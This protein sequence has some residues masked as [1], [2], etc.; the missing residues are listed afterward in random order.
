MNTTRRQFLGF[1]MGLA[2]AGAL[3]ALAASNAALAWRERVLQGFG[4]TL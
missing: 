4:S 2:A 3:P 1:G